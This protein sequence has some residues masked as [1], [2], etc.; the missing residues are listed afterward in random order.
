M[1]SILPN[2]KY[3]I[4]ISYRQ[5]D[6]KRD[7]WVTN[8]VAALKDELEATL[9]NPVSIY[10]DENPHDGLLETHQIGASLEGKLKC[11]VFIPIISQTYCDT[12]S[13]AWEH[14]FLSFNRM[15]LEDELGMNIT[16]ANGNVASR[17]LPIKIHDLDAED[18][19]ILEKEL[20]GP[21]RSIDF[22]Q[23][24]AGVNRPLTAEDDQVR[25]SGKIL[26][27]DQINKVANA[28]KEIGTSVLR[29]NKEDEPSINV[30]E[31]TPAYIKKRTN[32][33][34]LNK[35]L[36]LLILPLVIVGSY[37]IYINY[38]AQEQTPKDVGKSIAVLPFVDMS[39]DKDQQYFSDGISEELINALVKIPNLKVAGRTSSFSYRGINKNLKSI[40]EELEVA[41]ILE[42]SIRKSG[43]QFRITAQLIN[44]NDGFHLWSET[45]NIEFTDIFSV[46]DQI[47][48]AIMAALNVHLLK[49]S[50]AKAATSQEAYTAYLKGRE[51]LA[52]RGQG[53]IEAEGFFRE[54]IRL[55]PNFS[56]AYS[57]L[58]KTL[59]IYENYVDGA[60]LEKVNGEAK[61][62]ANKALELDPKNAEAYLVLGAIAAFYEWDWEKAEKNLLKSVE[63]SPNDGEMYNFLGDYYSIVLNEEK[64]IEMESKAIELD[65]LLRINHGNLAMT[66]LI[67][68]SWKKAQKVYSNA[69]IVFDDSSLLVHAGALSYIRQNQLAEAQ[70]IIDQMEND[71]RLLYVK[72]TFAIVSADTSLAIKYIE[73]IPANYIASRAPLY[74]ELEMWEE[75]AKY[76]EQAYAERQPQLVYYSFIKLP[77]DYPN[78]P[79]LQKAFDKPE[80]NALFE[81][82]RKNL[83]NN[84]LNN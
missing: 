45:F 37:F 38:A 41:T 77:E 55:D 71:D 30:E 84:E 6:N 46:Q 61:M 43:N 16:L 83:K 72:A 1:P 31:G 56:P 21:L 40:G 70:L 3:D 18:Q 24:A 32:K 59:S 39:P 22:I 12:K 58:G 26:Y 64:A 44:S 19:A 81:I 4:F 49:E 62:V 50:I 67:F 66:Y 20:E 25:E 34:S 11:I 74:L 69:L 10:F 68:N 8:F 17:V 54:A 29:K 51:K 23:R 48:K 76:I 13:F 75:A 35:I 80:L 28:L 42:G 7:G 60:D 47:T 53:I 36:G 15:A 73:A 9:K 27:S 2:Y 65:P 33:I 57:G 52:L 5:N 78:H 79:A 63:L 14:E 82:R